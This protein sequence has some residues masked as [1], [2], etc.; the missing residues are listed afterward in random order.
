[1]TLC[2]VGAHHQNGFSVNHIGR[3]MRGT[4]TNRLCAQRRWPEAIGEIVWLFT[5]KDLNGGIMIFIFI[6]LVSLYYTSNPRFLNLSGLG[7]IIPLV[8]QCMI[9][10]ASSNL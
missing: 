5:W 8:V 4:H 2:G 1:M 3:L 10:I 9:L 6:R 7:I